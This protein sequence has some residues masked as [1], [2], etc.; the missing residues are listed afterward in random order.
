MKIRNRQKT[1]YITIVKR[2]RITKR[3][4]EIADVYG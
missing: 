4:H 2:K 1:K 3:M